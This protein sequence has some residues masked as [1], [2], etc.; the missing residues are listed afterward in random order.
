MPAKDYPI[1]DGMRVW[2]WV[3][4]RLGEEWMGLEWMYEWDQPDTL[5]VTLS[6][7]D[8]AE[9]RMQLVL[10]LVLHF[11]KIVYLDSSLD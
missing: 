6:F 7:Y 11:L 8:S 1:V 9:F 5:A 2:I 4:Y 3:T 10:S